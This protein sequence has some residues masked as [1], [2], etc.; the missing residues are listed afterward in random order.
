MEIGRL[1]N[2]QGISDNLLERRESKFTGEPTKK[3]AQNRDRVYP[4]T[5]A[6]FVNI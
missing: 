4:T 6:E 3:E 5:K 2:L 1:P